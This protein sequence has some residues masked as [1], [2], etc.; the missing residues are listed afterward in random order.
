M[1]KQLV[2]EKTTEVSLEQDAIKRAFDV[3]KTRLR[4]AVV[5]PAGGGKGELALRV[6]THKA[7]QAA[8][9]TVAKN[10]GA[11]S[12][13][14]DASDSDN[15]QG[16]TDNE[17]T[18]GAT[19]N[20][21]TEDTAKNTDAAG[22][23]EGAGKTSSDVKKE[24]LRRS[25]R[26]QESSKS[27]KKRKKNPQDP[28][29]PQELDYQT[30]SH[31][32]FGSEFESPMA[33]E[34]PASAAALR[35]LELAAEG[36]EGNLANPLGF[37]LH[38]KTWPFNNEPNVATF[39]VEQYDGT[40]E[41]TGHGALDALPLTLF[42]VAAEMGAWEGHNTDDFIGTFAAEDVAEAV[43]MFQKPSKGGWRDPPIS[44]VCEI[45]LRIA[46]F[47][48]SWEG[49]SSPRAPPFGRGARV[50]VKKGGWP[51]GLSLGYMEATRYR[52]V[53][54]F[55]TK[56]KGRTG[57]SKSRTVP[58]F[59]RDTEKGITTLRGVALVVVMV[60]TMLKAISFPMQRTAR[61]I[62]DLVSAPTLREAVEIIKEWSVEAKET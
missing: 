55:Q 54:E 2:E 29:D 23:A 28:Q 11:E 62:E 41:E 8:K 43:A 18:E 46:G 20:A 6:E 50:T 61:S 44:L 36:E 34:T 33:A 5:A 3:L 12:N 4:D 17:D 53:R 51:L 35:T 30:Y 13:S 22:T 60:A 48:H 14:T 25:L 45:Y 40:F 31:I 42:V 16:A 52:V 10:T 37:W 57:K 27:K 7:V 39:F 47:L 9:N 59:E 38:G 21:G 26:Q 56:R 15:T 32:L 24:R 58:F 1:L 19:E 49:R